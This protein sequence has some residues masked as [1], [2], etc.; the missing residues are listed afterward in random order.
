MS[1]TINQNTRLQDLT[2]LTQNAADAGK[3]LRA[4]HNAQGDLVLYAKDG[5]SSVLDKLLGRA[6]RREERAKEAV[7]TVFGNELKA[8]GGVKDSLGLK[9]LGRYVDSQSILSA[10]GA[11]TVG[12]IATLKQGVEGVA[13]RL[14]DSNRSNPGNSPDNRSGVLG[15]SL[16]D[17]GL[18][19]VGIEISRTAHGII[20][21][22]ENN[23]LDTSK[24]TI[25]DKLGD[26]IVASFKGKQGT[27]KDDW[28]ALGRSGAMRLRD[29]LTAAITTELGASGSSIPGNLREIVDQGVNRALS[30]MLPDKVVPDSFKTVPFSKQSLPN[31]MIGGKEYSPS[32]LLGEGGFGVAFEYKAADGDKIAVKLPKDEQSAEKLATTV[33]DFAAEAAI[34]K[35]AAGKGC[36]QVLGIKG[37]VRFPDGRLAI[38]MEIAPN[39]DADK[40]SVGIRDLVKNGTLSEGQANV[41]RLTMIKDMA[42]GLQQ[43][44]DQ[45]MLHLDFKAPNCFVG[46]DGTVKIA[47]FGTGKVSGKAHL[48]DV[49]GNLNAYFLSPEIHAAR[50]VLENIETEETTKAKATLKEH[51]PQAKAGT[52][53]VLST[54]VMAPTRDGLEAVKEFPF[55][56][57]SADVWGLGTAALEMFTGKLPGEIST[58]QSDAGNL[59]ASFATRGGEPLADRADDKGIPLNGAIGV[60]TGH[61]EIDSLLTDL[62][63]ADP[64]ERAKPRDVLDSQAL[65]APGVGSAEAKALIAAIGSGDPQRID[66][67]KRDLVALAARMAL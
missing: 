64:K 62:L 37:E 20:N 58:F 4:K 7:K 21:A 47:D 67:A 41:L 16:R 23:G 2:Q 51:L 59:L 49:D 43:L 28:E 27:G 46:S 34:Q 10:Q 42:L 44:A 52:L 11:L 19:P 48:H 55:I 22:S 66:D 12:H 5:K 26:D 15:P 53:N 29:E 1:I 32:K 30:Q 13:Q 40:L 45:N 39:G 63:R 24:G 17:V 54:S 36:D 3:T 9:G 6:G 14:P 60:K 25:A 8:L 50:H 33:A 65:K 31:L 35:R 61:R 38:A 57:R 56:G 18:S